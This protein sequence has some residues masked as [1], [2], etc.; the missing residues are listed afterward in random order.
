MSF[1][2]IARIVATVAGLVVLCVAYVMSTE[3]IDHKIFGSWYCDVDSDHPGHSSCQS[4]T[5]TQRSREDIQTLGLGGLGLIGAALV[6][7]QFDRRPPAPTA[8]SAPPAPSGPMGPGVPPG[9]GGGSMPQQQGWRP[10][11]QRD[12]RTQW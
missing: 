5:L 2:R 3:D 12:P 7:G 8:P 4:G 10:E 6:M 1:L 11:Q 9:P